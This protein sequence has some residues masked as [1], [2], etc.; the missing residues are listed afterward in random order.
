[1]K[2]EKKAL[3]NTCP[4]SFIIGMA[5]FSMFFGSGNLTFPLYIG[6]I[7]SI[8]WNFA[9]L[10]FLISAVLL[11]F[12]G[13]LAMVINQGDVHSFFSKTGKFIGGKYLIPIL[14]TVWIPLGSA[15]R[16]ITVA[17][18]SIQAYFDFIPLWLFSIVYSIAIF[19]LIYKRHKLLDI[20]G[21]ILTPLLLLSLLLLIIAGYFSYPEKAI[22]PP[23]HSNAMAKGLLEGYN[24]MDL[25]A[26][27]F[28]SVSIIKLLSESKKSTSIPLNRK[29]KLLFKSSVVGVI[30]LATVYVGLIYLAASHAS[31]I[32]TLEKEQILPFLSYILLGPKL[33]IISSVIVLLACMTTSSV[34]TIVYADYL[35]NTKLFSDHKKSSFTTIFILIVTYLFS[36]IGFSGITT[37]TSPM[38]QV[39]YPIL[40]VL[41]ILTIGKKFSQVLFKWKPVIN[42]KKNKYQKKL[43]KESFNSLK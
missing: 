6:Q 2:I 23:L 9:T 40:I 11:P 16:C 17:H 1:M 19:F 31:T 7:T 43:K 10:G 33:G 15:P 32:E 39:L 42:S 30:I 14:L 4:S 21:Y 34:L 26:S 37:I 18:A 27:C 29:L 38:L 36:L 35:K 20:L 25:I 24:T 12:L 41:V 13:I 22:F 8:E 28:F 3:K 5:L